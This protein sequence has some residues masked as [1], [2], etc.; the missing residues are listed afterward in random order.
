MSHTGAI[1]DDNRVF[2]VAIKQ[3]NAVNAENFQQFLDYTK[4]FSL[5]C[6]REVK[7]NKIAI[8][9]NAGGALINASDELRNTSLEL[10]E[11][12]S[13][14]IRKL[15]EFSDH[16]TKIQNPLDM[17]VMSDN[18][19]FVRGL[20]YL[21]QQDSINGVVLCIVPHVESIK[22]K[23]IASD[24]EKVVEKYKKPVVATHMAGPHYDHMLK[25]FDRVG[26]PCYGVA[27][28]AVKALDV[29]MGY[30]LKNT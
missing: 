1:T 5:M 15:D 24:L 10:A 28:R 7:G 23:T 9:S 22:D 14:T 8:V 29:F 26:I 16:L 13:E 12:S 2:D 21:L 11:F 30:K 4:A 19:Y 17:A 27:E 3:A 6:D 25:N 20:E 18:N